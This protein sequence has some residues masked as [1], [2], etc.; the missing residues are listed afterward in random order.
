VR[1]RRPGVETPDGPGRISGV[2]QIL[3]GWRVRVDLAGGGC[4]VGPDADLTGPGDHKLVQ[5]YVHDLDEKGVK[6]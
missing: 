5:T 3:G 2:A 6:E 1:A 4:W